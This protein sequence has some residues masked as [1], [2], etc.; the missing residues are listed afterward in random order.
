MNIYSILILVISFV[1]HIN[2]IHKV[3][4]ELIKD[5]QQE[6]HGLLDKKTKCIEKNLW[7]GQ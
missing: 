4:V 3:W 2:L 6:T 7:R 1:L 5:R